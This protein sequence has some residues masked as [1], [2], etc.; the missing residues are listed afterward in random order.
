MT[1]PDIIINVVEQP[2]EVDRAELAF[3]LHADTQKV[4]FAEVPA[5]LEALG[6]VVGS[7]CSH[8]DGEVAYPHCD[9][10]EKRERMFSLGTPRAWT[11]D[12]GDEKLSV[13]VVL[14]D[15]RARVKTK[16]AISIDATIA[17]DDAAEP[18]LYDLVAQSYPGGMPPQNRGEL[19]LA[20]GAAPAGPDE[21]AQAIADASKTAEATTDDLCVPPPPL[22][23]G[24]SYAAA[25]GVRALPRLQLVEQRDP[26]DRRSWFI[27]PERAD[28][29]RG[30][31]E[32]AAR[33]AEPQSAVDPRYRPYPFDY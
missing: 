1:A 27:S 31:V 10:V 15:D 16:T 24:I 19:N 13:R 21:I 11:I 9:A 3:D 7:E 29:E 5:A 30:M 32:R 12:F 25:D 8:L 22:W 2:V 14:R 28:F 18:T 23:Q 17:D 20:S 33:S 4:I 6:V 26:S